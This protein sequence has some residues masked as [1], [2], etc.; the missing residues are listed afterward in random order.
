ML[1]YEEWELVFTRNRVSVWEDENILGM[2]GV[3]CA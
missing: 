3:G 1:A 2:D